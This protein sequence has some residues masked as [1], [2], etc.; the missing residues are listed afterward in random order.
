MKGS[1]ARPKGLHVR[2]HSP[3]FRRPTVLG[4]RMTNDERRGTCV[5]H[6]LDDRVSC[7]ALI[8]TYGDRAT[9]AIRAMSMAIDCGVTDVLL[10]HNG[11][12]SRVGDRLNE[13]AA[14]LPVPVRTLTLPTNMGSAGGYT[15][16]LQGYIESSSGGLVWM[17]DDDNEP[18]P[19]ALRAA[20]Q[21]QKSAASKAIP[22]S[23]VAVSCFRPSDSMHSAIARGGRAAVV[24][25]RPGDF[26]H[27][28]VRNRLF[29]SKMAK[30]LL[31]LRRTLSDKDSSDE[32][33][34][35]TA[36]YGGLLIGRQLVAAIG[37]PRQDFVL[38]EDDT[39]YSA[40]VRSAGGKIV[41]A[42]DAVVHDPDKE[43]LVC[44]T[45]NVRPLVAMLRT[46]RSARL[47]LFYQTRNTVYLDRQRLRQP[48]H[49]LWF[50][51][52]A[53]TYLTCVLTL[54]ALDSRNRVGLTTFFGAVIAGMRAHL[55]ATRRLE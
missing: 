51:L 26:N 25:P 8:V 12:T 46:P 44:P 30:T 48:S 22:P 35:P 45:K 31:G 34:V 20:L 50:L 29:I 14:K 21:V 11:L 4:R 53:A 27:F 6:D 24:F 23:M 49:Y 52:N 5:P 38:Y 1:D 15:R 55:G 16:G 2:V 33:E 19:G 32:I 41:L 28:D 10:V 17:L 3:S 36:P 13:A 37:L 43:E 47:R 40:R 9:L 7:T 18:E 42:I 54:A 39:E